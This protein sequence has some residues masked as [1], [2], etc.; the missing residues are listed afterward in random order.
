MNYELILLYC[1]LDPD[2]HNGLISVNMAGVP[3]LPDDVG[4]SATTEVNLYIHILSAAEI[5]K[6]NM[7]NAAFFHTNLRSKC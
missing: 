2:W 3:Y 1:I 5:L 4:A 7:L 6:T